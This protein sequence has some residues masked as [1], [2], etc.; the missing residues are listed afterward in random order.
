M[1]PTA[2]W[3]L[4]APIPT[5]FPSVSPSS[6]GASLAAVLVHDLIPPALPSQPCSLCSPRS[7]DP[8]CS[9]HS[10]TFPSLSSSLRFPSQPRS[11]H[12]LAAPV[13]LTATLPSQ[14][15]CP[16]SPLPGLTMARGPA[17]PTSARAL[18]ATSAASI[19]LLAP[20]TSRPRAAQRPAYV[21]SPAPPYWLRA[22]PPSFE[23]AAGRCCDV[24]G[25]VAVSG[26]V[27]PL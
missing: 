26:A 25:G 2:D 9:P 16:R 21:I 8:P 3:V 5:D 20:V 4:T 22:A 23:R 6:F 17:R 7:S 13:P 19:T 11:P 1:L 15:R 27:S 10:P 18:P 24:G 12:S 14:P